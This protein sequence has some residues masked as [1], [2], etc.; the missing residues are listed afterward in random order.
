MLGLGLGL[1]LGFKLG[2]PANHYFTHSHFIGKVTKLGLYIY[3]HS[4]LIHTALLHFPGNTRRRP[5]AG[6]AWGVSYYFLDLSPLTFSIN[7]LW[8]ARGTSL[9]R[10]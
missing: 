3:S 10:K 2:C 8:W 7:L 4:I 9:Y 1:G 5:V 6:M